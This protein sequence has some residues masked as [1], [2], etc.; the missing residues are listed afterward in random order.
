[1]RNVDNP[2]VFTRNFSIRIEDAVSME[3]V[4]HRARKTWRAGAIGIKHHGELPAYIKSRDVDENLVTHAGVIENIVVDVEDN[5]DE[6]AKLREYVAE[7]DTW[8]EHIDDTK[9]LYLLRDCQ[10]LDE[11]FSFTQLRKIKNGERLPESYSRQP[12]YVYQLDR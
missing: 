11:P 6:V 9:T 7:R 2:A 12:A 8:D 4:T 3:K 1:M 5:P 10:E